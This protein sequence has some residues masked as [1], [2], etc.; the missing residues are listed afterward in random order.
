MAH[1]ALIVY[2]LTFQ[3]LGA[4]D[5]AIATGL[6]T[7][8]SEQIVPL[9]LARVGYERRKISVGIMG[10]VALCPSPY[11][12]PDTPCLVLFSRRHPPHA[13]A[14]AKKWHQPSQKW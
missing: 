10:I 2:A 9:F 1:Y 5:I 14:A 4:Y 8:D 12:I 3:R 13:F 6:F 7:S 11:E